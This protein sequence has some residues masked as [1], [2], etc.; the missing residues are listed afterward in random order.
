MV[1]V[2]FKKASEFLDSISEK[3]IVG[4][5]HDNDSDGFCSASCFA[6]FSEKRGAKIVEAPFKKDQKFDIN[7][8]LPC[9]KIILSDLPP[10]VILETLKN[11]LKTKAEIFYTDHHEKSDKIP[12]KILEL[13]TTGLGYFPSSRTAYE[14]TGEKPLLALSGMIADA[15]HL[16][17]END[18]L[19]EGLLKKFSMNLKEFS[20]KIAYKISNT[21]ICL[22]ESPKELFEKIYSLEAPEDVKKIEGFSKVIEKEAEGIIRAFDEKSEKLGGAVFYFFSSK[23]DIKKIIAGK[24]IQMEKNHDKILIFAS[25]LKSGRI[26][27]SARNQSREYNVREILKKSVEPLKNST[28]GGHKAAAGA[29]IEKQDLEKFKLRLS[30]LSLKAKASKKLNGN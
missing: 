29:I 14:L 12:E 30:Q 24:I 2:D 25:P 17:P 13:R 3:D 5:I 6:S 20:E 23:F 19:I 1:S 18:E 16:Y 8:F 11:L 21:I 9:T 22:D 4:L 10:N 27:I 28:A 15:A 26:S 7:P